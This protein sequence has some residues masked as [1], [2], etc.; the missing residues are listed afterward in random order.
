MIKII[1][2]AN[3]VVDTSLKFFTSSKRKVQNIPTRNDPIGLQGNMTA[4][5]VGRNQWCSL[6]H[7]TASVRLLIPLP[8]PPNHL[9]PLTAAC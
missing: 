7:V 1:P 2:C 6:G 9:N 8:P 5:E 4:L 3:Q